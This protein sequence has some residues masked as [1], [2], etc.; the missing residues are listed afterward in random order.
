VAVVFDELVV[1]VGDAILLC[2]PIPPLCTAVG[3]TPVTFHTV[4]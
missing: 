3:G 1:D 4:K 2:P